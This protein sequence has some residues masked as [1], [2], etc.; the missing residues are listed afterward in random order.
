MIKFVYFDLGGVA[1]LD[2]SKTN[3]WQELNKELG[4]KPEQEKEY[5]EWFDQKEKEVCKGLD[6]ETLVPYIR[7]N[8]NPHLPKNYSFLMAFVNRFKFNPSI[9][10]VIQEIHRELPV[11]LLTNA[12]PNML[13]EIIKKKLL[14]S[15]KWD[16]IIDSSVVRISKP[17][18]KIYKLAEKES[19]F[20]G[21]EILFVENSQ[22]NI[23]GA[24]KCGWKTFMYDPADTKK[25]S[26]DL[27]FFHRSL[28]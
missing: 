7:K 17:D 27:L 18:V 5:T 20:K 12:Y 16:V 13:N 2:F 3:N 25:S 11:G 6:I 19:G 10:P 8:F 21:N 9:W 22:K 23:D 24:I 1:E 4:I 26:E 28:G 14:K 15:F